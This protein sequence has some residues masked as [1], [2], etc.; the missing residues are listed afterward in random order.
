MSESDTEILERHP[1]LKAAIDYFLKRVESVIIAIMISGGV[2]GCL[3]EKEQH[4]V[5]WIGQHLSEKES[6]IEQLKQ[7]NK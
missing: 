4:D 5:G 7:E 6:Q 1:V 3:H 2:G